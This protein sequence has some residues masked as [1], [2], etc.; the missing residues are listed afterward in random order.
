MTELITG[1]H[2]PELAHQFKGLRSFHSDHRAPASRDRA[3]RSRRTRVRKLA[4]LALVELHRLY[5]LLQE[6]RD[7]DKHAWAERRCELS[8]GPFSGRCNLERVDLAHL[9]SHHGPGCG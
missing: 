3:E 8:E 6:Q 7:V 1:Y 5:L 9:L 2:S 4:D